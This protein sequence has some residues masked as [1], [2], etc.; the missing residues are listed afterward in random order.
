[1]NTPTGN[2][3]NASVWNLWS[4]LDTSMATVLGGT[5]MMNSPNG[6]NFGG[7]PS[8]QS[9]SG[10]ALNTSAGYGNYNGGFASLKITDW[11]GVTMQSNFTWSK[12]LGTGAVVPGE[13]R[14][15][16]GRCLRFGGN[17]RQTGL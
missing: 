14:I 11:R 13:Q 5:T 4:D 6:G 8:P 10:V 15:Y 3:T 17:V 2:L 16:S 1:M 12:A 9:S 7:Q